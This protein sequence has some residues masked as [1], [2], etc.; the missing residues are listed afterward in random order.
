MISVKSISTCARLRLGAFF[1]GGIMEKKIGKSEQNKKES[2]WR[3]RNSQHPDWKSSI[4][5]PNKPLNL[6]RFTNL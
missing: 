6:K 1:V 5:N 3:D 4:G 2:I